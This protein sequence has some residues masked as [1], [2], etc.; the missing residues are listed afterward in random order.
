MSRINLHLGV[1]AAMLVLASVSA[2][3]A[4]PPAAA[5]AGLADAF[6]AIAGGGAWIDADGA[7]N[8]GTG[9][10]LNATAS[11]EYN[12]TPSLGVQGDVV[13]RGRNWSYPGTSSQLDMHNFEGALHGFTRSEQYLLGVFA[14]Y[15][16]GYLGI[17]DGSLIGVDVSHVFGGVEG[18]LFVGNATLYAQAGAKR[19]AFGDLTTATGY[20]GTFEARYYLQPNFKIEAHVGYDTLND[21]SSLGYLVGNENTVSL[22]ASGEYRFADTPFSVFAQYDYVKNTLPSSSSSDQ[23][24]LVGVKLNFDS[25]TLLDRDRSGASLK[26]I[27]PHD[28]D[29]FGTLGAL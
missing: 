25:P 5:P 15:G 16:D 7:V 6:V 8:T 18:Q 3:F 12:I 4:G 22:G 19:Y 17:A 21:V 28:F 24:V 23:R 13:Y 10:T 14:Q 27:E 26:P 11:G 9:R 20:F 2:S 29:Y 1:S